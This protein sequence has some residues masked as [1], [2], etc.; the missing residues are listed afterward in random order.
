MFYSVLI[1]NEFKKIRL[2]AS[3]WEKSES[4][5]EPSLDA[6][7]LSSCIESGV[8]GLTRDFR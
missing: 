1:E 5:T 6:D 2:E 3:L 8:S 7:K 4:V